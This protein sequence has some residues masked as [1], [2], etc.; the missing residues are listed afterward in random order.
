MTPIIIDIAIVLFILVFALLGI[1]QGF[2]RALCSFL[3]IFVALLGAVFIT[4]TFTSQAVEIVKPHLLPSIAERL[5]QELISE[6]TE[7]LTTT[8]IAELLEGMNLP[9]SW[10]ESLQNLYDTAIKSEILTSTTELLSNFILD[11]IV[12]VILFIVSFLLLLLIWKFVSKSL[13]LIARLPVLNFFNR[14]FGAL[15]GVLKSLIILYILNFI[16]LDYIAK[17]PPELTNKTVIFQ[18]LTTA[19]ADIHLHYVLF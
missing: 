13:D 4:K 3:A 1:K 10:A 2:V 16:L 19:F 12:S 14:T 8:E 5:N 18:Y 11:I 6:S 7:D 15:F 17:I 9:E